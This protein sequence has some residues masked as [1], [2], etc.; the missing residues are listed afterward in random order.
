MAT[1]NSK[2]ATIKPDTKTTLNHEGTTVHQLNALEVLFSKVLG[3]FFGESTH[4]EK[5]T[6]ESDYKELAKTIS[7]VADEDI[8]YVLKIAQLGRAYNMISYP[9]N[10]LT[11]CMNDERFK[12]ESFVDE[13]TG[14]NK[15]QT[16]ARYII[17]RGKDILDILATQMNVYG[18]SVV[19]KGKKGEKK[20]HHRQQPLPMQMRKV[21][22]SRLESF[23]EYQISKALGESRQ[24]SMSDA[25]KLLHPNPTKSRVGKNFYQKVIEGDVK[26]GN[27]VKQVQSEL[28]KANNKNSKT[29]K[30]DV[31]KS[32]DTS[33]VMAIVKNLVALYNNGVLDDL[34]A[35]DSIVAKLSNKEEVRKSKLLPFRFYS[36][37]KEV[38]NTLHNSVAKARILEAL[39]DALDSSIDNLPDINGYS[40]VLVDRSGSMRKPVS[41]MSD[42]TA[43]E[44]ALVLGAICFK[45]GFADVFVFGTSCVQIDDV[46]RKS[47][48][49]DIISAM[50]RPY[51]GGGTNLDVALNVVERSKARY[52]NLIIL[53]DGDCY[54]V[55][56]KSF[57]FTRGDYSCYKC[58]DNVN[59]L[60]KTGKVRKVYLDNLLGNDFAI[61]NTDD[62][63]K[64]LITGFSERIVDMINVYSSIGGGASDVRVV[65]DSLMANIT[66]DSLPKEQ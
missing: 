52:D 60:I 31:V 11:A 65:I 62:Y 36:A 22:K 42:V 41:S 58:D 53:S 51:C 38:M 57:S 47:T 54:S 1:M 20:K 5:R 55:S 14:R 23:N 2:R 56:G 13:V 25:I 16:Y 7:D 40:A 50:R 28:A 26:M 27:D 48:V 21:L 61:I 66:S 9:L 3:S 59:H 63:R 10:V 35:V 37:Y 15:L 6:A 49:M 30:K 44:V 43:E 33:T 24:V 17:R 39:V 34:T 46:T 8:E 18:F 19:V 12:G 45:K 4:Y 64:N 32:I 29:T